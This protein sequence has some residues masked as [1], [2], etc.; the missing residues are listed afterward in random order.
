MRYYVLLL[1]LL[2]SF[3]LQSQTRDDYITT[4]PLNNDTICPGTSF[5]LSATASGHFLDGNVF[6][7]EISDIYGDFSF[8]DTI[9][10]LQYSN[11]GPEVFQVDIP[12]EIPRVYT[13]SPLYRMRIVSSNPE[14]IGTDNGSDITIDNFPLIE[15]TERTLCLLR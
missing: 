8:P 12:A 7:A 13:Y 11:A 3:N 9:A 6:Y 14:L 1:L 5:T 4:L 10:F 2:I 15:I